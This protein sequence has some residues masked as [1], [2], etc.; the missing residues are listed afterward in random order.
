LPDGQENREVFF[1]LVEILS[2]LNEPHDR[3]RN[4]FPFFQL[5]LATLLGFSPSFEKR[6]LEDLTDAGGILHMHSGA[7]SPSAGPGTGHRM[8]S[9]SSLRAFGI[10]ARAPIHKVLQLALRPETESEVADLITAYMRYHFEDSYPD[11]A[12]RVFLQLELN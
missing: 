2:V 7:I 9:R 3:V 11:R 6:D 1:T 12:A 10:F 8:A 5:R 4:L